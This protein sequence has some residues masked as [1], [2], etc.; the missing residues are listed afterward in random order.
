LA[1][2]K[3]ALQVYTIREH[4]GDAAGFTDAMKKVREIGYEYVELAGVGD[5]SLADQKRICDEAGLTI[6]ASH[7]GYGA[8]AAD[9]DA[10]IADHK[11]LAAEYAIVP[12][13]PGELRNAEGYAQAAAAMTAWSETLA[14]AGIGLAYHNH[15]MEFEKFGGRLAMD[16]LFQDS[17]PKVGSELDLYWVQHGGASPVAWIKRL[18]GRLPLLHLKDFEIRDGEQLF[19]EVGEGN[20][21]WDAIFA[22][23][24]EAG[25][26]WLAVEEDRCT[27][28]SMESIAISFRNLHAMGMC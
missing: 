5:V 20:L 27:R 23:A 18:A 13:L 6:I 19:A 14:E 15:D 16:I 25:T 11:L 24:S 26:K 10:V 21:E 2:M 9:L 3:V 4:L 17:G 7:T 22:A 1:E 12:G 8:F 28:P